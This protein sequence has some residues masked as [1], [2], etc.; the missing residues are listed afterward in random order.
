MPRPR[1]KGKELFH[2]HEPDYDRP[3]YRLSEST[4][5]RIVQNL[6]FL[7]GKAAA[8]ECIKEV[9]RLIQVYWAHKSDPMIAWERTFDPAQR[10]TEEDVILITYGDLIHHPDMTPLDTLAHLARTYLKGTINTLHLL[11]FFPYSSDRGF[12]IT[13]FEEVDPR[14]GSWDDL[15]DLKADFRLMFDA[16]F[17]HVSSQSRWF[18][19]FRNDHPRYRDFFIVFSTKSTL[20]PEQMRIITRPR[21]T[22]VLTEFSTLRGHR[23]VWTTFSKDQIDLNYKNPE[24][25]LEVLRIMLVYLYRGADILRLDAVTYLWTEPGTRCAH[26]EQTHAII[27][28]FRAVLDAVNPVCALITE[29]NAPHAENVTYFG[30]GLDEAHMVYNF[31]L[32]PLTLHAFQNEDAS[33]LTQ[34]AQTLSHVSPQATYFNFLDSHDGIGV[35]PV[36]GILS[37]EEIEDMALRVVEHGGFISYR[38]EG[39]GTVSP[40]ELNIT[41]FSAVNREDA[42]EP[43]E[44]QVKRYLAS[45]SIALVFMGVPGIYVHGLLGSRNDAEAVI[46]EKETRSINRKVLDAQWLLAALDD[47]ESMTYKIS[48]PYGRMIYK[49]TRH[50][51]FHPN[52]GQKV[53]S[54]DSRVFAVARTSPDKAETILTITNVSSQGFTLPLDHAR[55]GI[56]AARFFDIL[57]KTRHKTTQGSFSL[58]VEPYGVYWLLAEH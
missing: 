19:E 2:L 10:F 38:K 35:T 17:N 53:L 43:A 55:T 45:R 20:T 24:V 56:S 32:P 42:D 21:P 51:A 41:W 14:L 1:R 48:R 5:K 26:L 23:W 7:Y 50:T 13:D 33:R 3:I 9:E 39:D 54:L 40:Y 29:T 25:L 28:L 47:P 37:K 4:R 46:H 30:T 49:R 15:E 22:E 34:W 57:G 6:E 18:C 16:V 8:A 27:R 36:A 58:E 52:G 11:P 12:A 31:A 44:I